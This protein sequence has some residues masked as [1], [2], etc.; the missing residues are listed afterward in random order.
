MTA[1]ERIKAIR[2]SEKL[3]N[4]SAYGKKLGVSVKM[5]GLKKT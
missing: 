3:Q 5:T 4:K 2:L 1:K